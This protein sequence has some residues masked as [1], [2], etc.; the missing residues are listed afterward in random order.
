VTHELPQHLQGLLSPNAYPHPVREV[1]LIT[2]HVSWVLLTGEF[3]YKIKRPVHYAFI[4]LRS[5][6]RRAHFCH[7]E[8]RLNLRFAPELYLEVCVIREENGQAT[9]KGAG[10]VIEHAVR[11]RQFDREEELDRLLST[12]RVT[13]EELT[14]FGA[15]LASIHSLMPVAPGNDARGKPE[16]IR[17]QI[18]KNLEECIQVVGASGAVEELMRLS[19][20]I[21]RQLEQLAPFMAQRLEAGF[22][23]ECHGDLHSRNIVRRDRR[24]IAF[25]CME[26]E[27]AFRWIDVAEEVAFLLADLEAQGFGGAGHAFLSGYTSANGDYESVRL[28]KLYKAHRAL[29]RAKVTALSAEKDARQYANYVRTA[30]ASLEPKQPRLIL[31]S[32]LSG[33]GKTWLA[34]QIAP[35]LKAIHIRSD[36][37]RKLLAGIAPTARR[38]A[39]PEQGLY[40]SQTTTQAYD[41]L[42]QAAAHVLGGGYTIIV[43]ATFNRREERE[44]FQALA[45]RCG[46]RLQVLRCHAPQG[47][48]RERIRARAAQA[49]DASDADLEVLRWQEQR[50]EAIDPGEGLE[51]IDVQTSDEIH[52]WMP[53]LMTVL[54]GP[55]Q[56]SPLSGLSTS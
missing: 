53:E 36:V 49:D 6:E 48:L 14:A 5:E 10:R 45:A 11:M 25:D 22:V 9:F 13:T 26:F 32:G 12:G 24:L 40:G 27:A 54:S 33:S 51:V 20:P 37:E 41:R 29:V 47:V 7:E 17:M 4:D 30:R 55:P 16:T 2:T 18:Q 56:S 3:T 34:R 52:S 15:S 21:S 1:Q 28:L 23:R 43:D 42:A 50:L 39:A 44:R 38:G 8:L 46:A 35:Q 31:M 19:E